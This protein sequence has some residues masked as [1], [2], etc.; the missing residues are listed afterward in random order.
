[1]AQQGIEVP[2]RLS[3]I[4]W[5]DNA[6]AL[7]SPVGLTTVAQQSDEMARLAIDRLADRIQGREVD[8]REIVLTSELR[9]RSST[10]GPDQTLS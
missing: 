3:V 1:M 10:A 9:V 6:T 4:G 7:L 8:G 5:D 2:G